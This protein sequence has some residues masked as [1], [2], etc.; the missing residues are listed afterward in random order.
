MPKY[1]FDEIID[2]TGTESLKYDAGRVY[3]PYLPD[4]YIPMWVADMDF[5]CAQPMLD[6]MHERLDRRILGYG[7]YSDTMSD[8]YYDAILGW[9]SRRHGVAAQKENIAFSTSVI[10]SAREAVACM[11]KDGDRVMINT[12]CY[13]YLYSPATEFPREVVKMPLQNNVGYYTIDFEA[14]EKE[15]SNEKTTLFLLCSPHN[16]SGRVWSE[17]ELRKMAELCFANNVRIF[18]D[19]IHND[20]TRKSSE[21][22]S[23]TALYPQD[24][25]IVTAMS[26]SKSFNVAGNNHSYVITYDPAI[27]N[28][29]DES[30]YCGS[31]NPLSV[32]A[33]IAAYNE[34]E[35]W[36]DEVRDYIDAN[37]NYLADFIHENLPRAK[38][39]IPEGTYLAW[40]DL[41]G[42]GMDEKSLNKKISTEG[43]FLE[44]ASDF[45]HNSEGFARMNMACPRSVVMKAC[46]RL[47][48]ALEKE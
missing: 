36:I 32:A 21:M 33:I 4:D 26:T 9:I 20:L 34:C 38:F 14:F 17:Q 45:V 7:N 40:I 16:P 2:R 28:A 44:Y 1:N 11:S 25:R 42:Y 19:E 10:D 18:V 39:R 12:P 23:L 27:K 37:M 24:P 48:N 31:P 22:I 6:A 15:V 13:Q 47:K 29:F 41:S 3:N 46:G 8:K 5:A 35:D 30:R 43:L